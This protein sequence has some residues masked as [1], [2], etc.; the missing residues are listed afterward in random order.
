MDRRYRKVHETPGA[1]TSGSTSI[2]PALGF[3]IDSNEGPGQEGAFQEYGTE[4]SEEVKP[5]IWAE[6]I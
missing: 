3:G 4:Q 1:H 2:P 6:V 5:I